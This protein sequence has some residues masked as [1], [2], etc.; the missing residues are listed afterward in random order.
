MTELTEEQ[1]NDFQNI[2]GNE[3]DNQEVKE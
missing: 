3:G 1:I 2:F